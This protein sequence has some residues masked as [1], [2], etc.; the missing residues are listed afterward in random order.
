[1]TLVLRKEELK[2]AACFLGFVPGSRR[3][4]HFF[5]IVAFVIGM[6]EW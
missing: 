3:Q 1:M 4:G 5:H 2:R 6:S